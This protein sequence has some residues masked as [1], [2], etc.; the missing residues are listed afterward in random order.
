MLNLTQSAWPFSSRGAGGGFT[1]VVYDS[2]SDEDG[3]PR[4]GV[5]I[6]SLVRDAREPVAGVLVRVPCR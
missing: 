4:L 5:Y 1:F 3:L 2:D 6:V